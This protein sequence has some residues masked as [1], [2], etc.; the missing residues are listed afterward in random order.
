[1]IQ[2]V[3]TALFSAAVLLLAA[4]SQ[5]APEP[6]ATYY[7]VRHAEKVLDIKNPPL[8]EV[9]TARAED[10]KVRLKDVPLT[11]IYSTDYIRTQ[12]TAGPTAKAHDLT[13]TSY[14]PSD[15]PGFAKLLL[16]QEGTILVAGHSNTTPQLAELLE[17][18]PG[19]PIIEATEY[20]RLYIITRRGS[21]I[22]GAIETYGK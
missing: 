14:D 18:E 12:D 20:D 2:T 9:G 3:K 21:V 16:T 6:D 13:V 5:S 1:M 17:A 22:E 15:L 4:C 11:A 10:L 8:T 19:E 7:L